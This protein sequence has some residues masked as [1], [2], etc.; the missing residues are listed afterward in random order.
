MQVT[1]SKNKTSAWH[2][3]EQGREKKNR[4]KKF[5]IWYFIYIEVGI[6]IAFLPINFTVL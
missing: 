3:E 2:S 5:K 6:Y 1:Q 4:E